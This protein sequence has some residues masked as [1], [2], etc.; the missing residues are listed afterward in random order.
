MRAA[1]RIMGRDGGEMR[2]LCNCGMVRRAFT[3][4]N[5]RPDFS[6]RLRS[7]SEDVSGADYSFGTP[8]FQAANISSALGISSGRMMRKPSHLA[9]V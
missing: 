9:S 3:K 2:A 7:F 5:K 1:V 6:E 8:L 4:R